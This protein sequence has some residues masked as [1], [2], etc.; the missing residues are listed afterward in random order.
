[1]N[2]PFAP[3]QRCLVNWLKLIFGLIA[4]ACVWLMLLPRLGQ[5]PPV[6]Q[7]IQHMEDKDIVVDAMFYTE[8]NWDPPSRAVIRARR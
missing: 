7:H 5:L 2:T 3:P 1:M 8:L 4:I 6:K